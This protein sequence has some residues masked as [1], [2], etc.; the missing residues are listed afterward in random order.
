MIKKL[1]L[2]VGLIGLLSSCG[3]NVSYQI[4]GKLSNLEEETLYAV[5]ENDDHKVVDT[6]TCEKPGQFSLKR[7]EGDFNTV[8]LFFNDKKNWSTAYL[9]KG[10]K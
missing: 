7:A 8:T 2:I 10:K 5:F 1:L 6:I 3:S 4:E 9:V